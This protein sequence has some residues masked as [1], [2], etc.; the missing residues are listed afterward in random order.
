MILWNK[1]QAF[2]C[3]LIP[4]L[5]IYYVE[6]VG[7]KVGHAK[8]TFCVVDDEPAEVHFMGG[9]LFIKWKEPSEKL[10]ADSA[11]KYWHCLGILTVGSHNTIPAVTDSPIHTVY[12]EQKQKKYIYICV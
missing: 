6:I 12:T 9:L 1:I 8:S 3:L 5:Q 2:I 4:F 11:I 10:R 7:S